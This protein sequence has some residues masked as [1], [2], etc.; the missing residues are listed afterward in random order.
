MKKIITLFC[1]I[2]ITFLYS[3]ADIDVIMESNMDNNTEKQETSS[4]LEE[5]LKITENGMNEQETIQENDIIM[6]SLHGE[7]IKEVISIDDVHN[8]FRKVRYSD[9]EHSEEYVQLMYDI[10]GKIYFTN[11]EDE[12]MKILNDD[13]GGAF[14]AWAQNLMIFNEKGFVEKIYGNGLFYIN[15]ENELIVL[16]ENRVNELFM[17]GDYI[18]YAEVPRDRKVNPGQLIDII[19]RLTLFQE[20]NRNCQWKIDEN[21]KIDYLLV[22]YYFYNGKVYLLLS[23]DRAKESILMVIYEDGTYETLIEDFPVYCF[24]PNSMLILDDYILLNIYNNIIA[25]NLETRKL[26]WYYEK[27]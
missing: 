16:N 8:I 2:F 15:S 4:N 23:G 11:R 1:I 7:W 6:M 14:I 27:D 19:K 10:D 3:C 26:T 24:D 22:S 9:V 12:K 17:L 20:Q 21:F 25:Y 13:R 18:Y 5:T